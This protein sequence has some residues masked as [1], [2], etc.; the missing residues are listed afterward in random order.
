M[1]LSRYLARDILA[2]LSAMMIILLLVFLGQQVVRYLNYIAVGKIPLNLLLTLVSFEVPYLLA[3][4]L[5]LALY[6]GILLALGRS[7]ADREMMVMMLSGY[8]MTHLLRL[9][10]VLSLMVFVVVFVLMLWVNPAI[11]AKRQH[12][13]EADPAMCH[14]IHTLMPGR[15]QVSADGQQVMYVEQLSRDHS[16]AKNIFIARALQ[17]T[18]HKRWMVMRAST[19]QQIWDAPSSYFFS[20]DA[21]QSL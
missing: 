12:L 7:R 9:V 16:R 18:T 11:S 17:D 20:H 2:T 13:M 5:P 3:L 10:A 1:I 4:L 8:R 6:L 15:F 14:L 19:G 21:W